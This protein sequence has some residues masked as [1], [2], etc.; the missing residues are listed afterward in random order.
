MTNLLKTVPFLFLFGVP[1]FLIQEQP[2]REILAEDSTILKP[3]CAH[4][5]IQKSILEQK[6]KLLHQQE[7][8]EQLWQNHNQQNQTLTTTPPA[9]YTLP[10]VVHIIHNNGLGNIALAAYLY[11]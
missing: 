1:L 2:V 8:L 7:V 4:D 9:D 6:P 10:I 3:F 11:D 5:W